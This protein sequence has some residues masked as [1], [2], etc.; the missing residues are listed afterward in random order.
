MIT[1]NDQSGVVQEEAV[2]ARFILFSSVER[3][4]KVIP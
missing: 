3:E 2:K 4:V 1:E